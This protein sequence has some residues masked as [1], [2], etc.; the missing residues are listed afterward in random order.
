MVLLPVSIIIPCYNN[1]AFLSDAIASALAQTHPSI[2]IIVID[3]GST[4]ASPSII[5]SFGERIYWETQPNQ[6][7]PAARNR[8]L[9]LAKGTY[10]KFLD[11]DDVL[12]PNC[13]EQQVNLAESLST[14]SKAIVYGNAQWVDPI[15]EKLKVENPRP[16]L[17]DED[18][19]AHILENSPLTS[20]PL[21]RKDYL[22]A[23]GGFDP[24]L[25]KGQEHDL[26]LRLALS[27]VRFVYHDDDVYQYRNDGKDSRISNQR[28]SKHGPLLPYQTLQDRQLLIETQTGL[29]IT[30]AVR[31]ILAQQYWAFGR[32]ILREGYVNE[33]KQ[34]F[35]TAQSLDQHYC[36][37]GKTPY[38]LLVNLLGAVRA[39]QTMTMLKQATTFAKPSNV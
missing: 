22:Q 35:E 15:G 27:G 29:P 33:A 23:I 14:K 28:L 10:I 31:R 39:E 11:A 37:V 30:A 34:Y 4:D 36:V 21:H 12:L 7:A 20:C 5:R 13:I 32:G 25:K 6:G 8:G 1:A 9:A 2:E 38:P 26:H 3:D 16:P 24:T 19:I 17:S 18:Q